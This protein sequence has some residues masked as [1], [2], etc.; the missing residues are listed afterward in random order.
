VNNVFKSTKLIWAAALS[1]AISA[2]AA[3]AV[4]AC[5]QDGDPAKGTLVEFELE[6]GERLKGVYGGCQGVAVLVNHSLLG[7]LV[8]PRS[9]IEALA[10]DGE[11][12]AP[13]TAAAAVPAPTPVV[14][15]SDEA[16]AEVEAA[17]ADA[18]EAAAAE[19]AE[20]AEAEEAEESAW[21]VVLDVGLNGSQGNSNDFYGT[22]GTDVTW[23]RPDE[24]RQWVS[25]LDYLLDMNGQEIDDQVLDFKT[26]YDWLFPDSPW[27][28]FVGTNWLYS[29]DENWDT[30]G[31]LNAGPGYDIIMNDWT[32]L[33]GI[34]GLGVSREFGGDDDDFHP[35]WIL[36]YDLKQKL[37]ENW[38]MAWKS[39]Y[40]QKLDDGEFRFETELNFDYK[41]SNDRDLALRFGIKE[42]Y[43][44]DPDDG[45]DK[46]DFTYWLGLV[47]EL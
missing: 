10:A 42:L 39:T 46:D 35:E 9:D 38:K 24:K 31:V 45:D 43:N 32:E 5:E 12:P 15:D 27:R 44:S 26:R 34:T 28:W 40:F 37:T 33:L 8:I 19:A 7:L 4:D 17:S 23:L 14:V 21:E 16:E 3:R 29:E 25:S 22:A 2:G 13:A 20:A 47:Y 6:T 11:L 30:R 36:G 18:G 41:L 1:V